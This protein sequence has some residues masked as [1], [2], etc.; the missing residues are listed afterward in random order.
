[1]IFLLSLRQRQSIILKTILPFI[2]EE[3]HLVVLHRL[4]WIYG[5]RS[6]EKMT[7]SLEQAIMQKDGIAAFK[8]MLL[9]AIQCFGKLRIFWVIMIQHLRV[10]IIQHLAGNQKPSPRQRYLDYNK[11]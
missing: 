8:S 3:S 10:S 11:E 1:M 7:R 2:S 5:T 6:T 9:V 4:Q